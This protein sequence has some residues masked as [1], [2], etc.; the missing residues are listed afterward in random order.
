MT[1]WLLKRL[2]D[3]KHQPTPR[4]AFQGTVNWMRALTIL[5]DPDSFSPQALRTKYS[6]VQRRRKN[7]EADTLVF[8]MLVMSLHNLSSLTSFESLSS[9]K[10]EVVR[11]A[12]VAWYYSTY[13]AS[14]AMIAACS[15]SD[16]QTHT[17]TA[18]VWQSDIV[19]RGL[20][21]EPFSLML[22]RVDTK[23]VQS[24]IAVLRQGNHHDLNI[25]PRTVIEA[26]GAAIS[27][28]KGTAEYVKWQVEED[29]KSS[30]AFHDLGV[31]NFR[32]AA[33]R[34][35][36]DDRLTQ[37]S[38]NYLVQAFRYRGKAHYRDSI[39]LSYGTDRTQVVTTLIA[40]LKVVAERFFAMASFYIVKR[41]EKGA[42]QNFVA[43]MNESLNFAI[44]IDLGLIS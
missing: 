24:E 21:A 10:Y 8:E 9:G 16:P 27:Y 37:E 32:S 6:A 1:N 13:Y 40:D 42:W 7:P 39:Y 35:L 20:A 2:F 19:A 38:V 44:P 14:K 18:K 23:T 30:R 26:R 29:L 34:K 31:V 3:H 43:D 5:A 15:G 36:R 17:K 33:A 28:L 41:V 22:S 4:F 12:I 25:Q 11:S